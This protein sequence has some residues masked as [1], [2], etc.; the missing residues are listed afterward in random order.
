MLVLDGK[1]MNTRDNAHAH[2][3][4]TMGFPLYEGDTLEGLRTVLSKWQKSEHIVLSH[5]QDIYLKL[6]GYGGQILKVFLD[7]AKVNKNLTVE[8]LD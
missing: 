1:Q 8:Y 2:I 7:S 4:K 5:Y 3:A 6:Q